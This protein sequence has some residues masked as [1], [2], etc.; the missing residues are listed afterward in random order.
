MTDAAGRRYCARRAEAVS[1]GA[2]VRGPRPAAGEGAPE[3]ADPEAPSEALDELAAVAGR[4]NSYRNWPSTGCPSSDTTLYATV[5][6]PKGADARSLIETSTTPSPG[7]IL[8]RPGIDPTSRTCEHEER[9]QRPALVK[10]DADGVH[11]LLE[12][13]RLRGHLVPAV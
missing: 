7:P 2:V 11:G 10:P 8:H 13:T 12:L 9:L 5:Y 6:R 3:V 1:L 4:A